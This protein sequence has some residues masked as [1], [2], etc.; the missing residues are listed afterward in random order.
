MK[1]FTGRIEVLAKPMI[2]G[3][4]NNYRGW[5]L[6]ENENSLDEGFLVEY[7]NS[8]R[9]NHIAHVNYISWI[10]R[11]EFGRVY[12]L[13]ETPIERLIV[14]RGELLYRLRKL[15]DFLAT[16]TPLK[17]GPKHVELLCRQATAMQDYYEVLS[18]RFDL[19]RREKDQEQ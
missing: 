6:P 1:K 13:S 15:K 2:R 3:E 5:V 10:P 18:L 16:D 7:L 8:H 19:M 12:N 14:E 4:Y 9:N 17:L 11:I